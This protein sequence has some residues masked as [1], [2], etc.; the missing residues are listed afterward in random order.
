MAIDFKNQIT[1]NIDSGFV[2]V[3]TCPGGAKSAVVFGMTISNKFSALAQ[4]TAEARVMD[5]STGDFSHFVA[6]GTPIEIG[7]SLVPVG[8]VQKI[9]LE[10]GDRIEVSASDADSADVVV[11]VLELS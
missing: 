8:G 10:P 9:V 2:T 4:I 7:A 6:P 1:N 3:Y 5:L 11:S